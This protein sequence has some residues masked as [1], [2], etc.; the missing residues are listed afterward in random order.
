MSPLTESLIFAGI[1]VA[2]YSLIIIREVFKGW[3][4]RNRFKE[5]DV[6][7]PRHNCP[8]WEYESKTL[9]SGWHC[10]QCGKKVKQ[11]AHKNWTDWEYCSDSSCVQARLCQRCGEIEERGPNHIWESIG[12]EE[13][14][15]DTYDLG[16]V[17]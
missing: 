10:Y 2:L 5:C 11:S 7:P 8:D 12:R 15:S 13:Y 4:I 1:C 6:S 14:V 9:V 17:L 3:V 16:E